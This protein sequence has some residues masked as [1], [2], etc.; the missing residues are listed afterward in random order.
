MKKLALVLVLLSVSAEIALPAEI[1]SP[2]D[3]RPSVSV[4]TSATGSVQTRMQRRRRYR[5]M[6]RRERRIIRRHRRYERRER[7]HIRRYVRRHYRRG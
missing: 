6:V 1:S 2:T 5:R 7:R 3:N 4:L